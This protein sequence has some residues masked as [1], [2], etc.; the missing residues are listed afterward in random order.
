[1]HDD[2][3]SDHGRSSMFFFFRVAES[4]IPPATTAH[5]SDC[6]FLLTLMVWISIERVSVSVSP[7]VPVIGSM[8]SNR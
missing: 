3:T 4:P 1:M 8:R 6:G 5:I 7:S 2:P